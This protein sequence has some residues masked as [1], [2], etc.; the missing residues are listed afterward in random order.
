MFLACA[1]SLEHVAKPSISAY[2]SEMSCTAIRSKEVEEQ[3]G[4][5]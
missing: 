5:L 4:L 3:L 2:Q 1:R